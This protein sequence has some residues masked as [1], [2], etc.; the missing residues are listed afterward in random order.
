MP[1]AEIVLL[2]KFKQRRAAE[3]VDRL[4]EMGRNIPAGHGIRT[5]DEVPASIRVR[6][7]RENGDAVDVIDTAISTT[8][9]ALPIERQSTGCW[10]TPD[11]SRRRREHSIQPCTVSPRFS[12]HPAV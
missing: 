2:R 11:M 10:I 1:A 8:R 7:Q 3:N 12:D 6:V 5:C 4:V 9:M